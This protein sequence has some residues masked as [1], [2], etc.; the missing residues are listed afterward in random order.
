M[1]MLFGAF[2][3]VAVGVGIHYVLEVGKKQLTNYCESQGSIID[4]ARF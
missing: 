1:G 3:L 4:L 2:L